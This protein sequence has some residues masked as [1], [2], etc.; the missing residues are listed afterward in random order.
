MKNTMPQK[1][2][3]MTKK[4]ACDRAKR[5]GGTFRQSVCDC[6]EIDE[7]ESERLQRGGI[8]GE[9]SCLRGEDGSI[10]AW[11]SDDEEE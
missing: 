10:F 7:I 9:T 4:E 2:L 5:A 3:F 1:I 8:A 11:W 6:R